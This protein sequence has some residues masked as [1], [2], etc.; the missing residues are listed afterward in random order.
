MRTHV[1][2]RL[3]SRA[4]YD[5]PVKYGIRDYSSIQNHFGGLV[6]AGDILNSVDLMGKVVLITGGNSGLGELESNICDLAR[7]TK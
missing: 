1:D 2:P 6:K 3:M 5:F 7:E 4:V